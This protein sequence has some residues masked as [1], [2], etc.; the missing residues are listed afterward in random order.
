[1]LYTSLEREGA[2]AEL[3][4]HWSQLTPLPSKPAML[5]RLAVDTGKTLR[6]VRASLSHLGI[7]PA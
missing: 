4:Y 3:S 6:L 7:D 5:H 2:L 1:V